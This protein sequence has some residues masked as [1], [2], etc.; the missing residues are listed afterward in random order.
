MSQQFRKGDRVEALEGSEA[1]ANF[2]LTAGHVYTVETA[3]ARPESNRIFPNPSEQYVRV[4]GVGHTFWSD[5]FKHAVETREELFTIHE[6]W[7][8]KPGDVVD[9]APEPY[10]AAG[11]Q[12][13]RQ[14]PVEPPK[15]LPPTK[16]GSFVLANG[17]GDRADKPVVPLLLTI[18]GWMNT[19]TLDPAV[20]GWDVPTLQER[21][22]KVVYDAGADA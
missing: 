5:N 20:A 1:V 18:K 22:F 13:R 4:E 17:V 11:V 7:S 12:V 2:A 21:G 3:V 16:V 15:P 9:T 14:V 19:W 10:S 6:P 8:L